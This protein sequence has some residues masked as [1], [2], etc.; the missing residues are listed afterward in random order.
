MRLFEIEAD[1]TLDYE[2]PDFFSILASNVDLAGAGIPIRF[3]IT[4]PAEQTARASHCEIGVISGLSDSLYAPPDSIFHFRERG[5]ENQDQFTGVFIVPTGIGAEIGGHAGDATPAARTLAAVCDQIIVNPNV[6]NAADINE[7]SSNMLYVEGS[8]ISRLMMGTLGLM[9]VRSNRLLT[10]IQWHSE[11]IIVNNA[12]N[13]VNAARASGGF[14]CEVITSLPSEMEMTT[15]YSGAG[16]ATGAITGFDS[17]CELVEKH[18]SN[19]D[20]VAITTVIDVDRK[21]HDDYFFDRADVVNPW[22]GVEA[23]LTHGLSSIFDIPTAHSPMYEDCDLMNSDPDIME[24]RKAA[25]GVSVS[26][27]HSVLKGLSRTPRLIT[28]QSFFGR[29]G[30]IAA[31]DISCL[32]VPSGCLGIP[33]LAALHQGIA[34]IEVTGNQNKMRNVLTALPWAEGQF[35]RVSNYFE[36]AGIVAAMRAGV[37]NAAVTRP[38]DLAKVETAREHG[39]RAGEPLLRSVAVRDQ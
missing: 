2:N 27:L 26:F 7:M 17:L 34:V 6:V 38:I 9:P 18:R 20:A 12:I 33:V 24:P 31:E 5:F 8:V 4:G 23:L 3:V 22:G 15:R 13:A 11:N 10:I 25:E 19:I 36:A 28:D 32:V 29:Q 30:V 1:L 35:Y 39:I 16:R 14:H 37:M 21:L